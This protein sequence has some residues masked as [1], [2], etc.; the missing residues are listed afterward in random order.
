MKTAAALFAAS[1]A[2]SIAAAWLC[3]FHPAL[4]GFHALFV[5]HALTTGCAGIARVIYVCVNEC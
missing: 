4:K 1:G 2:F 5:V 3:D